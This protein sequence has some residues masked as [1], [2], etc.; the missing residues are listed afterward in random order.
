MSNESIGRGPDI[1]PWVHNGVRMYGDEVRHDNL[2]TAF[3]GWWCASCDAIFF[4]DGY[5]DAVKT[6]PACGVDNGD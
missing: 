2:V 4:A 1:R 3:A 5:R 6:H